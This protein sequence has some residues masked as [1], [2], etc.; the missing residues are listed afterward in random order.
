MEIQFVKQ[1]FSD[2]WLVFFL[3][4]NEKLNFENYESA[5]PKLACCPVP[6]KWVIQ[7]EHI[8]LMKGHVLILHL[9]ARSNSICTDMYHQLKTMK[10]Q[11]LFSCLTHTLDYGLQ[12]EYVTLYKL[13]SSNSWSY[14]NIPSCQILVAY[15]IYS[16]IFTMSQISCRYSLRTTNTQGTVLALKEL[17]I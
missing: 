6:T 2:I 17:R 7:D 13:T 4:K 12:L 14:F 11:P 10:L 9:K 16:I 1:L 5:S 3:C 15:L 8:P